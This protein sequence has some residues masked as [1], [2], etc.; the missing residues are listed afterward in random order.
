[1]EWHHLIICLVG[2][3]A[4]YGACHFKPITHEH[5][6]PRNR[7]RALPRGTSGPGKPGRPRKP[8]PVPYTPE[9]L[10]LETVEKPM[11]APG[12]Y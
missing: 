8:K 11:D 5:R 3:A 10:P 1:M 2:I 9:P 6:T 12:L 4:G 7:A